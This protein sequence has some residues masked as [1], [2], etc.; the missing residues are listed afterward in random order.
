[1][2]LIHQIKRQDGNAGNYI[3][4]AAWTIDRDHKVCTARFA[5]YRN[6]AAFKNGLRPIDPH[7]A[8]VSFEGTV[9]GLTY[10]LYPFDGTTVDSPETT[11]YNAFRTFQGWPKG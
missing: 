11:I 9:E 2:G 5:L 6:E 3:H 7:Y 1:M 10:P 4:L 8:E